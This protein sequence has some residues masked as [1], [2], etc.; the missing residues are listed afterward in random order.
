MLPVWDS[1]N[2]VLCCVKQKSPSH[3]SVHRNNLK[4]ACL[5]QESQVDLQDKH[6]STDRLVV[7]F[8]GLV[9]QP[10]YACMSHSLTCWMCKPADATQEPGTT[11]EI[12][13]Y[14]RAY[15]SEPSVPT[16]AIVSSWT[17]HGTRVW[18]VQYNQFLWERLLFMIITTDKTYYKQNV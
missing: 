2:G 13:Y 6:K 9:V 3:V 4:L 15:Y 12:G 18:P 14:R 7:R 11:R 10:A 1:S 16:R 5:V 8:K 17:L